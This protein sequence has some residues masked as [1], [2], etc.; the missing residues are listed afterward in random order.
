MPTVTP[1]HGYIKPNVNDPVDA[2]LWGGMLNQNLDGQ[3]NDILTAGEIED[4]ADAAI[5][6]AVWPVMKGSIL[7]GL[8]IANNGTDATNDI[9]VAGGACVS[10]DGT[11]LIVLSS[12]LTK[13]IDAE[14]SP[15]SGNGGRVGDLDNGTYDIFVISKDGGADPDVII[16]DSLS[17]I[18]PA[19]YTKKCAL[20]PIIRE[21]AAIVG[22]VQVGRKFIRQQDVVDV[23]V[24]NSGLSASLRSLSVPRGRSLTAL[25]RAAQSKGGSA[26]SHMISSPLQSDVPPD[27]VANVGNYSMAAASPVNSITAGEFAILTNAS[28]QIRTRASQNLCNLQITTYGW[29]VE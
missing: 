25:I 21:S 6:S 19:G 5:V 18:L 26:I 3:D 12:A 20:W 11:T 15:G 13:R 1:R 29:I 27:T 17:P 24:S 2:D 8:T 4:I 22:F 7:T 9:D 10:D 28:G 14:F 16:A 23:N